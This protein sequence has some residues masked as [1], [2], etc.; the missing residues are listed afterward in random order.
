MAPGEIYTFTPVET[1]NDECGRSKLIQSDLKLITFYPVYFMIH[2]RKSIKINVIVIPT[3]YLST[4]MWHNF[5]S[6]IEVE[7]TAKGEIAM[8]RTAIKSAAMKNMDSSSL[9]LI[10]PVC[11]MKVDPETNQIKSVYDTET[12]YFCAEG[13][14]R[15]FES[16]PE[17]YLSQKLPRKKGLWGRYL[18]RLQK[19][20]DG[21][22]M[23]CC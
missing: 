9:K 20:T 8:K 3:D 1:N 5:C 11:L 18:D 22:P 14:K 16:D 15:E 23:K 19:A 12:Y 6:K 7:Q 17:K 21:K 2:S 10:D 4:T 13:C